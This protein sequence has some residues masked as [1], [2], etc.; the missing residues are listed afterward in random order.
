MGEGSSPLM[1][2]I[3]GYRAFTGPIPIVSPQVTYMPSLTWAHTA[4]SGSSTA[5][6]GMLTHL[7]GGGGMVCPVVMATLP[8]PQKGFKI[9]LRSGYHTMRGRT[10]DRRM[11]HANT[12]LSL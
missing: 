10:A 7:G 6:H 1:T 2:A 8:T 9:S 5:A 12:D 4:G 11:C 3:V